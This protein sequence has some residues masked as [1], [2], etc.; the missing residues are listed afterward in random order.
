M[1]YPSKARWMAR[2]AASVALRYGLALVSVAAALG[3]AHSGRGSRACPLRS[4]S[5]RIGASRRSAASCHKRTHAP[6]QMMC[7]IARLLDHLVGALLEQERH[8]ETER[9]G[10]LQIDDQLEF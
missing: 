8:V 7:A 4:D 2:P 3:W 10:G 5:D 9:L 1:G 6:Q